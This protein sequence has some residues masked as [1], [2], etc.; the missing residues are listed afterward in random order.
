MSRVVKPLVITGLA[1]AVVAGILFSIYKYNTDPERVL[2]KL[3]PPM[4]GELA[5]S[6]W[7]APTI[8]KYSTPEF[9]QWM[10]ANKLTAGMPGFAYLGREK[11]FIDI[12]DFAI[13]DDKNFA[14]L[15]ADFVFDAGPA[16]VTLQMAK[17]GK[18]WLI[19]SFSVDSPLFKKPVAEPAAP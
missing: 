12:A 3:V 18:Y 6:G 11:K 4:V 9:R 7:D 8:M 17:R 10:I 19:Y 14:I 2:G 13:N 15:K 1:F 16:S 5:A